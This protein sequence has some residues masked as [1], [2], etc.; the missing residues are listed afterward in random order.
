M[1]TN[2]PKNRREQILLEATKLFAAKGFQ[3]TP[4]RGIAHC[5]GISEAAIYRH[6]DSKVALYEDVIRRKAAQHDIVGYFEG[7]DNDGDIEEIL[8]GMASHILGFLE[9][10]P[11]LLGLMFN[12]TVESG[13]VSAVLFREVRLPYIN[14]LA[15]QLEQR[16]TAGEVREVE[17]YITARCFTGM[18]MDCALSVGVWNKISKLNF[19]ANDVI[20]NNVPIFARGLMTE[21]ALRGAVIS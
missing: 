19:V 14:Y 7:A 13:P 1:T 11:E 3:G 4:I 20:C 8:T 2:R 12:N 18:V 6:F 17:P 9:K 5:C 15:G 10:D 16:M 21:E